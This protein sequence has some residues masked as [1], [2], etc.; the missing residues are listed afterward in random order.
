MVAETHTEFFYSASKKASKMFYKQIDSFS[1][2]IKEPHKW[3]KQQMP[4][5]GVDVDFRVHVNPIKKNCDILKQKNKRS[6]Y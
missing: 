4:I 6:T 2:R 1:K 3:F 5:E